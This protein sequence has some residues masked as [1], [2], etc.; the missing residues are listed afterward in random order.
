MNI[1]KPSASGTLARPALMAWIAG[2]LAGLVLLA[3]FYGQRH[4]DFEQVTLA[5]GTTAVYASV[6][7]D[8]IHCADDRDIAQCLSGAA[9]R[10]ARGAVL[11]LGNSQLHAVNQF[12]PGEHSAAAEL[13]PRLQARGLDLLT[14]SQPNANLQEHAV[15][16]ASLL[17]RLPVAALLLPVVFDDMREDG[18]RESLRETL[19]APA[20]AARLRSF[21][22]G[23]AI[24]A[25]N[26]TA[27]AGGET[28]AIRQTLQERLEAAS[29]GWLDAHSK[30]W[31]ARSEV[32]GDIL[33]ALYGVRNTV[34]GIRPDTA[35]RV[36]P[37]RY[38]ANFNALAMTLDL[39]RE[40]RIPVFL[41][42]APIRQDV[43][44]PYVPAQY[45]KFKHE[46]QALAQAKGATYLNWEGLVPVEHWGSKDATTVGG[47]VEIDY[48]HFRA[49]G[50]K[51]LADAAFEALKAVR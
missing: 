48:M 50:H 30:A 20:A 47:E 11:W 26:K 32:R 33:L 19:H 35:R 31:A 8:R 36:I 24:L 15:L 18:V 29:T 5:K 3:H 22:A 39:A 1:A 44:L 7:S 49:A 51:L 45:E 10:G 14:F 41:Y 21:P 42:V 12:H 27:P 9:R 38:E 17:D 46:I 28:G 40:K 25:A 23:R 37:S 4:T 2:A 34:F 6:G 43:K 16:T 13:F